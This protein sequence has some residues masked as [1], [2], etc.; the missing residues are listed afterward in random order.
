MPEILQA[1]NFQTLLFQQCFNLFFIGWCY[2]YVSMNKIPATTDLAAQFQNLFY[3]F[4][5]QNL[6]RFLRN[7]PSLKF[8]HGKLPVVSDRIL[9]QHPRSIILCFKPI[10]Q[11]LTRKTP[12]AFA[13]T[14]PRD[15]TIMGLLG[16]SATR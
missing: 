12:G 7:N 15:S 5:I 9:I 14:T 1:A 13:R 4:G 16:S 2:I 8:R 10:H 6:N 11:R 3:G